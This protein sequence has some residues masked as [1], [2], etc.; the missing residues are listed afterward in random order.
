IAK[1]FKEN[2]KKYNQKEWVIHAPY[3]INFA[4][5]NPKIKHGSV[6]VLKQELERGTMLGASYIMTHLG[7]YK[8]VGKEEGYKQLTEGLAA[9]MKGYKGST[10]LLVEISAGSGSAIG[11]SF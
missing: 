1:Q 10:K 9:I 8:D 11:G 3:F 2:C 4:S 5:T 6:S 7:S